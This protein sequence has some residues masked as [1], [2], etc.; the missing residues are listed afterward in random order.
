MSKK[1]NTWKNPLSLWGS[2]DENYEVSTPVWKNP[3][4]IWKKTNSYSVPTTKIGRFHYE[5]KS[6]NHGNKIVLI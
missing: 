1:K 5:Y 6:S 2:R 3:H 4:E